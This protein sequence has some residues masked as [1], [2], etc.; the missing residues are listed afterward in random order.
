MPL[1]ARH[2]SNGEALTYRWGYFHLAAIIQAAEADG[3]LEQLRHD[4]RCT[5]E[6]DYEITDT[7]DG[8]VMKFDAGDELELWR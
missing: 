5:L 2:N 4:G 3:K 7:A 6:N 8:E 1:N